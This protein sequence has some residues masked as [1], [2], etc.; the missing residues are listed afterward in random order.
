MDW[1]SWFQS[2][3]DIEHLLSL[4]GKK[5]RYISNNQPKYIKIWLLVFIAQQAIKEP[6]ESIWKGDFYCLTEVIP[7]NWRILFTGKHLDRH[8]S[9]QIRAA[10]SCPI[11]LWSPL[12]GSWWDSKPCAL[13]HWLKS[14]SDAGCQGGRARFW[15]A[16]R[17]TWSSEVVK[18]KQKRQE[19]A[20]GKRRAGR[21]PVCLPSV[22][23]LPD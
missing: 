20:A 10:S 16:I 1:K 12:E 7:T 2:C 21:L 14:L 11:L 5:K 3:F 23:N 19:C 18:K 13:P 8:F 15:A 22:W 9:T 17:A 6:A 4:C